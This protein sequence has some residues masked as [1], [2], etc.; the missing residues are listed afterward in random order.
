[1]PAVIATL[2][3]HADATTAASPVVIATLTG[4]ADT[5]ATGTTLPVT[6]AIPAGHAETTRACSATLLTTHALGGHFNSSGYCA[7]FAPNLV[8]D[9]FI[10][11][12]FTHSLAGTRHLTHAGATYA[13]HTRRGWLL[14]RGQRFAWA[15]FHRRDD[16]GLALFIDGECETGWHVAP[17]RAA[18]PALRRD[19]ATFHN[20]RL[21]VVGLVGAVAGGDPKFT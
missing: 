17:G 3:R 15:L 11:T 6:V 1:M 5:T 13:A 8:T 12:R 20:K 14:C 7:N 21:A 10:D 18:A 19:D 9:G 2:P 4:H 16:A